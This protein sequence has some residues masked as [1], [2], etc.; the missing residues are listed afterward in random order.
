[1]CVSVCMCVSYTNRPGFKI[2]EGN[3]GWMH[4]YCWRYC[5]CRSGDHTESYNTINIASIWIHDISLFPL[6]RQIDLR[7]SIT[8]T[9]S[10]TLHA[11]TVEFA[12]KSNKT[13]TRLN[14]PC[15][16]VMIKST[17]YQSVASSTTNLLSD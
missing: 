6:S 7:S 4:G 10:L 11:G 13:V 16:V 15:N 14:Q 1:M 8:E 2:I 12:I 17:A 9:H 3:F 5:C